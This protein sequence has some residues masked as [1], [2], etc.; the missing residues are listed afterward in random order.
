MKLIQTMKIET[1]TPKS[2]IVIYE[3]LYLDKI[4]RFFCSKLQNKQ[5]FPISYI[6]MDSWESD[7]IKLTKLSTK[8]IIT[9]YRTAMLQRGW[10]VITDVAV[11][12]AGNIY[13]TGARKLSHLMLNS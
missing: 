4:G 3:S 2:L 13:L 5:K 10:T 11:D 1:Q 6:H 12:P 9:K 7:H 8:T